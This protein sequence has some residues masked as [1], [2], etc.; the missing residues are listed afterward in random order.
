MYQEHTADIGEVPA[1][2]LSVRHHR[3]DT[4]PD[5]SPLATRRRALLVQVNDV[6]E[7]R[8]QARA[9]EDYEE[10]PELT[11]RRVHADAW[12]AAFV[13][14]LVTGAPELTDRFNRPIA[15]RRQR[16]SVCSDHHRD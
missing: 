13:W 6:D 9:W 12:S 3:G 8:A 1:A 5:T 15:L 2:N 11:T 4:V 14:P 10:S 16:G 7:A